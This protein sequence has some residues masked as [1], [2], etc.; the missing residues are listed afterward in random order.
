MKPRVFSE[1]NGSPPRTGILFVLDLNIFVKNDCV[2]SNELLLFQGLQ[3]TRLFNA[4]TGCF[5]AVCVTADEVG[6]G[7]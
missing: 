7:K 1:I 6:S 2:R 4:G 3:F 5:I